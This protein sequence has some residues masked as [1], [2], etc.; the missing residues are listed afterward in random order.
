MSNW[1]NWGDQRYAHAM[2][3]RAIGDLPEMESSKAIARR[4]AVFWQRGSNVL[5]VGCG[6]GHYLRSLRREIGHV[7]DYTGVDIT[8]DHLALAKMAF[9]ADKRAHFEYGDIFDLHYRDSEFDIVICTN[10]LQNLPSIVQP[11]SELARVARRLL[12]VRLLCGNRTFLIRDVHQHDPELDPCGEPYSFNH[13]NIYSRTYL[14]E[15]LSRMADIRSHTIEPDRD[16][17]IENVDNAVLASN[18][19]AGH[20]TLIGGYQANG[21]ILLPWA[22]VTILK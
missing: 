6:A 13:Y 3:R 1:Q 5:D 14:D 9:D 15:I 17:A 21:Y 18:A 22:F 7:F 2:Y 4:V 8:A 11:L 10:L 12:I 16:Y 20:T 19:G